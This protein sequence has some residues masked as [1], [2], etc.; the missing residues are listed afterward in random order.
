M[1]RLRT[2]LPLATLVCA[3]TERLTVERLLRDQP[4][5]LEVY[6]NPVTEMA[7]VEFD[8]VVTGCDVLAGVLRRAGYAPAERQAPEPRRAAVTRRGP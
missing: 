1:P 2:A 6:V 4:G 3:G 8:S 7:Y 5:V